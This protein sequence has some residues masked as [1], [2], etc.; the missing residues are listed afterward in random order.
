MTQRLRAYAG[1][2]ARRAHLRTWRATAALRS[3]AT[4]VAHGLKLEPKD[5]VGVGGL[6]LLVKGIAMVYV[7][8][9]Y[10][11]TG[12]LLVT[13]YLYGELRTGKGQ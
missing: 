10:I 13:L 5:A 11:V 7:P 12:G 9:A 2:Y 6:A 4:D 3:A 1:I 8:A